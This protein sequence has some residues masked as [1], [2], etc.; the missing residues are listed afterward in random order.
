MLSTPETK[1]PRGLRLHDLIGLVVGYGMAALLVR[2]FWPKSGQVM[3]FQTLVFVLEFCWL[4]LAMSGPIV[5][6]L[7]RRLGTSS[8]L[9]PRRPARPGRWI[10]SGEPI[11]PPVG[12]GPASSNEPDSNPNPYTK[13]ELAWMVI[14]GYWI[15]LTMFVV[16]ALSIDTPWALVGLLQIVTALILWVVVPRRANPGAHA[17]AWTHFAALGLLWTW[18]FAWIL[19]ILLS[20]GL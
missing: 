3:V 18:P 20:R 16:P 5:L 15:G 9:R 14:G 2:S 7:D 13:A 11:Q 1:R 17:N 19:L 4:G 10:T 12:R 6:L 8:P